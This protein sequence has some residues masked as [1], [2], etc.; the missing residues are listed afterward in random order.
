MYTSNMISTLLSNP[1]LFV[2]WAISLVVVIT[3]HEYAHALVAD[4]LGDPSPRVSG[5]VT[6]NP[7]SHLDPLGTLM[8]LFIGFG[9]GKPVAFDP[10]NLRHPKRDIA[11]IA[12]AGPA[13]NLAL[14]L[15]LSLGLNFL[16]L[17]LLIHSLFAILIQLN[18]MLAIFNLVPIYPLDGEKILKGILPHDLA[19]EYDHLMRQYG[20]IIL[21]LMLLPIAGGR[22]PISAL[23]SPVISLLS[24]LL[25]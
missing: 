7:L 10:Y 1:L 16:A 3:I 12:L 15:I 24:S 20:T 22:S 25:I 8:I 23:I 5:R 14:A 17:P 19:V 9:W 21:V 13:S 2:L 6:L 18:I 11:M 4:R